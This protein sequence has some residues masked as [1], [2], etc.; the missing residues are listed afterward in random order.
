MTDKV[1]GNELSEHNLQQL[2]NAVHAGSDV[3]IAEKTETDSGTASFVKEHKRNFEKID[4]IFEGRMPKRNLEKEREL[5][6]RRSYAAF[7]ED[8]I[9][10]GSVGPMKVFDMTMKMDDCTE[11]MKQMESLSADPMLETEPIS[12]EAM[13]PLG[14]PP[15]SS[16]L[17]STMSG[18]HST[19][20][21]YH[22]QET[23]QGTIEKTTRRLDEI[24]DS[25]F[26]SRFTPCPQPPPLIMTPSVYRDMQRATQEKKRAQKEK[27]LGP[28]RKLLCKV[29]PL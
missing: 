24:E 17:A 5:R 8:F 12:G 11:K 1:R 6:V 16:H 25:K 19:Q 14:R 23:G 7:C 15:M 13:A 21:T 18:N 28:F 2:N 9:L 29:Q 27:L 4:V 20:T 3:H 10:S 22:P 26:E